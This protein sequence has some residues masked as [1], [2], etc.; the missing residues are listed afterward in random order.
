MNPVRNHK[1]I[2]INVVDA[3]VCSFTVGQGVLLIDF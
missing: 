2:M 3:I 1:A